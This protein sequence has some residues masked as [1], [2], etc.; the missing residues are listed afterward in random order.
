RVDLNNKPPELAMLNPHNRVPVLD[1]RELRL[2]ESNIINE[3][4]DERFP[5]PQLMPIGVS[6]KGASRLL[7]HEFNSLFAFADTIEGSKSEKQVDVARRELTDALLAISS[8]LTRSKFIMG[9]EFSLA[10]ATLAPLLWRLQK[11]RIKL[12]VRAAP[13]AKYAEMIF[14]RPS[15]RKSL[16]PAEAAMRK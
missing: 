7:M 11:L 9:S 1:D 14:A 3:Y 8:K 4:I 10:D 12:P 2:Y 6:E 15:F 13:L 16:T 5:H